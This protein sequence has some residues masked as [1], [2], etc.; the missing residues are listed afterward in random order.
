VLFEISSAELF[1][2][3]DIDPIQDVSYYIDLATNSDLAYVDN[4]M[5]KK[6]L[7]KIWNDWPQEYES[8][9][10]L[11]KLGWLIKDIKQN[12]V[13]NPIQLL[14]T[15]NGKYIAHPGTARLLILS[16]I[17]PSEKIKVLYVWNKELDPTPFFNQMPYQTIN[18]AWVFLNLF[19]KSNNFTI[20]A[21][22]LKETTVCVDGYKYFYFKL[23]TDSLKKIHKTFNLD[24][25]TFIDN[26][27][28]ASNIKDKIYFRDIISFGNNCCRLG[29]I[30]FIKINNKWIPKD[31]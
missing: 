21:A 31:I 25:I 18:N 5:S 7:W 10:Y 30:N 1:A 8:L 28:W 16:Y 24:F 22:C 26:G 20:K 13:D 4:L 12:G 29:G 9:K 2:H 14:Q 11:L 3:I 23:A 27:H 17:L 19:K 6:K 15:E